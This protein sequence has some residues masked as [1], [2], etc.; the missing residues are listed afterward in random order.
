[1][2]EIYNFTEENVPTDFNKIV[3]YF[4]QLL[5]KI[6]DTQ[7]LILILDSL[8]QLTEDGM[9]TRNSKKI[10]KIN[11]TGIIFLNFNQKA[12]IFMLIWGLVLSFPA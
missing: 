12:I 8:D 11:S 9:K 6:P 5:A 7:P 3:A 4:P 1:M 2:I 10:I